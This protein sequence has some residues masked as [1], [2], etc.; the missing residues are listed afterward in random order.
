MGWL[1]VKG[2][3]DVGCGYS[4]TWLAL[5]KNQQVQYTTAEPNTTTEPK[6]KVLR[7]VV[8]VQWGGRRERGCVS[9]G[10]VY[11]VCLQ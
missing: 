6:P 1:G 11:V 8:G 9:N 5:I 3:G 2:L 4:L 10:L 7:L